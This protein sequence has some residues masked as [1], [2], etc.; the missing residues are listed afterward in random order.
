MKTH[1]ISTLAAVLST[2]VLLM[3]PGLTKAETAAAHAVAAAKP[4]VTAPAAKPKVTAKAAQPKKVVINSKT[5]TK[6]V[7]AGVGAAPA[8]LTPAQLAVAE[9][10]HVGRMPCELGASVTLTADAKTPGYFTMQGKNFSYRM[11]PVASSTGTVRLEDPKAG[12]V[13]LQLANKSMLMNQKQGTRLADECMSPTQVAWVQA[14]KN[15]P[16]TS[17]PE[18]V[19]PAAA[20]APANLPRPVSPN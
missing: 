13:W 7:A 3:A 17:Q 19:K 6:N 16:V 18:P 1:Q 2:A 12:A 8:G 5:A 9:R 14:S 10:V 4:K 15:Q 20:S 11:A